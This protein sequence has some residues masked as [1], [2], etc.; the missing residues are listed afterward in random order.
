ML[1][2]QVSPKRCGHTRG[3]RVVPFVDACARIRA[4]VDARAEGGHDILIM[5]RTDSLGTDGLTEAIRRMKAFA[6]I[7]A[8]I[9]FMEAPRNVHEMRAFCEAV[10]EKPKMANLVE[11]GL[12]PLL[13]PVE[14]AAIGY[15]ICARPL[16]LIMAAMRAMET[17]L[18]DLKA[19]RNPKNLA[20]F[21]E[22]KTAVGYPKYY[23]E[24]ERY[25]ADPDPPNRAATAAIP[26]STSN[27]V[28]PRDEQDPNQL[29]A[30][31]S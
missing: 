22:L 26:G 17:A 10:P 9:L 1:E 28:Y 7:G 3:K 5:A 27:D 8:D 29:S 30:A 20:S 16:T 4:A 11:N 19:G 23:E 31:C 14:L 25:R 12:T 15:Q 2:D 13:P 6:E 21:D 18:A 24:E